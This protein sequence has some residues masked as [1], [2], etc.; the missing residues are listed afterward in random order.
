MAKSKK[1]QKVRG[2]VLSQVGSDVA[3]VFEAA[4]QAQAHRIDS[5]GQIQMVTDALGESVMAARQGRR[6]IARLRAKMI[7]NE[8]MTSLA[9]R[10]AL[11]K[12]KSVSDGIVLRS[13]QVR[14]S[15]ERLMTHAVRVQEVR[16]KN[17][18]KVI[19]PLTRLVEGA[20]DR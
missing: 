20:P 8:V 3:E 11:L 10:R 2:E 18:R 19:R 14:D 6:K 12:S 9:D 15:F 13:H 5:I 7:E 4:S 16:R 1:K 17:I